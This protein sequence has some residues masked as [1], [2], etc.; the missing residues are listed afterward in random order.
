[1]SVDCRIVVCRFFVSPTGKPA[2]LGLDVDSFHHGV[3]TST[4]ESPFFQAA[5]SAM[6][7]IGEVWMTFLT[8]RAQLG[9]LVSS[10]GKAIDRLLLNP[11]EQAI[12]ELAARLVRMS[13]H[14]VD[15]ALDMASA[16]IKR[17]GRGSKEAGRN[18]LHAAVVAFVL[19]ALQMPG[20][21]L[22]LSCGT[23]LAY[24][25]DCPPRSGGCSSPAVVPSSTPCRYSAWSALLPKHLEPT[26]INGEDSAGEPHLRGAVLVCVQ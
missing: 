5:G 7:P 16:P 1:M 25:Q 13:F 17:G 22:L 9:D 23:D 6:V 4:D 14:L 3:T 24:T 26:S 8:L 10:T 19:Q 12:R 20:V 11:N 18:W 15:T 21:L 2:A